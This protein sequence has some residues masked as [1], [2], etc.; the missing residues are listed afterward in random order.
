M[1]TYEGK[2]VWVEAYHA[3]GGQKRLTPLRRSKK[4]E[5]AAKEKCLDTGKEGWDTHMGSDGSNPEERVSHFSEIKGEVGE[6]LA[7]GRGNG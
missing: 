6:S 5:K 4:L 1:R 7:F 2:K 3:I